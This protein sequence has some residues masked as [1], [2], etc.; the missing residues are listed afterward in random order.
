MA[1]STAERMWK[2]NR[3]V[4]STD[5]V[6]TEDSEIHKRLYYVLDQIIDTVPEQMKDHPMAKMLV[7]FARE[8]KKDLRRIPGEFIEGL[9]RQ[10]GSAFQWVADGDMADIEN[11][12]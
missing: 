3:E 10:I 6:S 5:T 1:L 2:R 12:S 9:S 8:G 7:V 4:T 11:E